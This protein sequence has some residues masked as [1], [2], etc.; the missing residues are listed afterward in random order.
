[1]EVFLTVNLAIILIL[2]AKLAVI[3]TNK[4]IISIKL[5]S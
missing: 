5:A 1:M 4:R 2:S 3:M